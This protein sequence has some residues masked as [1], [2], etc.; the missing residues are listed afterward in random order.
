MLS[1]ERHGIITASRMGAVMGFSHAYMRQLIA[2]RNGQLLPETGEDYS[3]EA[4]AWGKEM[5]PRALA[6]YELTMDVELTPGRFGRH[7]QVPYVGATPDAERPGGLVEVKCPFNP[8][9]HLLAV[10]RREVPQVYVPQVQAELWVTGA[11]MLDYLSFD[12]RQVGQRQAVMIMVLPDP[13]YQQVMARRCAEFWR[14]VELG[15]IP[16]TIE[17]EVPQFF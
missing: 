1:P 15:R 17:A 5:E 11:P 7:P 8:A 2:E 13:A 10:Y 16:Q 3:G 6:H 9:E 12:P 14:C 4:T